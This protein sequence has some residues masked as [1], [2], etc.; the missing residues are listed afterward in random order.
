MELTIRNLK[1]SDWDTLVSWWSAWRGWEK[2]IP[3][4][5][6]LPSNGTGGFI[7]EKDGVQIVAGFV[8]L[9]NSKTAFFD[10]VISNPEYRDK[11]RKD[12]IKLLISGMEHVI[13]E[14][15]YKYVFSITRNPHL[16]KTHEEL[17]Y[18]VDKTKSHELVKVL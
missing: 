14:A 12:A 18:I 6:A 16:L 5:D 17:G 2:S 9:S 15:G 8:Y 7:V 10:W 3:S 11:D 4:K 13:K 1:E